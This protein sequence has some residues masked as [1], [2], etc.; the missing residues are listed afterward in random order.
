MDIGLEG[1]VK[2][3][4]EV[5][6]KKPMKVTL[7]FA[8]V[9]FLMWLLKTFMQIFTW[10]FLEWSFLEDPAMTNRLL[11]I[12]S[13]FR[14]LIIMIVAVFFVWVLY[15]H[16]KFKKQTLAATAKSK[17]FYEKAMAA[18]VKSKGFNE[19]TMKILKESEKALE[20]AKKLNLE[21]AKKFKETENVKSMLDK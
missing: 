4:E 6:G 19:E 2:K 7:W 12:N 10:L 18:E 11:M 1:L 8:F 20:E 21:A 16:R 14:V 13:V 9:V 3:F 17:G 15:L 5:I